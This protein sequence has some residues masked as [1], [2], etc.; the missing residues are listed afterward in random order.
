MSARISRT[1]AEGSGSGCGSS[2]LVRLGAG[3][4]CSSRCTDGWQRRPHGWQ[5]GNVLERLNE[6]C[7]RQQRNTHQKHS[8]HFNR[9]S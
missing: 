3:G 6:F 1:R 5:R 9:S 4:C 8:R 2:D 7:W